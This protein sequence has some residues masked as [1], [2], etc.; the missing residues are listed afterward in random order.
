VFKKLRDSWQKK[1]F[2]SVPAWDEEEGRYV[3]F[4]DEMDLPEYAVVYAHHASSKIEFMP[5]PLRVKYSNFTSEEMERLC[6]G[7]GNVQSILRLPGAE[8]RRIF[9]F[10]SNARLSN[11]MQ[12]IKD[13]E[14]VLVQHVAKPFE[15]SKVKLFMG[16]LM[17]K[18]NRVTE[19]KICSQTD[20][21]RY[22]FQHISELREQPM[23]NLTVKDC[24]DFGVMTSI[25]VDERAIDGF[26]KMLDAKTN[27]CAVVDYDG[28]LVGSLSSSDLRGMTNEKLRTI[29]LPVTEFFI[30]STGYKIPPPLTCNAE[31]KLVDTMKK[32]LKASTRRC[33]MVDH[34]FRPTG[35]VSM[36]KIIMCVLTNA[37][38]H[39]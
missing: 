18:T 9:V 5:E 19:Y 17:T 36:G 22:L 37:C 23:H 26:L 1:N 20:V 29:L 27:A 38:E 33:W 32:I 34:T 6:F 12:I 35:Y 13:Y 2:R 10:H 24:G 28:R 31:D 3:G 8:R 21:L 4:I 7:E 15:R 14:R 16:R 39:L 25:T 11:A 30:A